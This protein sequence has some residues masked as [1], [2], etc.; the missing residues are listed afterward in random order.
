[1]KT[2]QPPDDIGRVNADDLAVGKALGDGLQ[3]L[4]VA[5]ALER[6]YDDVAVGDVEIRV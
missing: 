6:G 2:P 3:G 4:A 1:M 5:V